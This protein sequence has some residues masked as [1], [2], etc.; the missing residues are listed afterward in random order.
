MRIRSR[1]RL[2]VRREAG[3]RL[4][5]VRPWCVHRRMLP[6]WQ[7]CVLKD[8]F[9]SS[10]ETRG[11]KVHEYILLPRLLQ[12]HADVQVEGCGCEPRKLGVLKSL[13]AVHPRSCSF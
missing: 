6:C 2:S 13:L 12:M 7:C 10:A 11:S 3:Q 4:D 5:V 8:A 1:V 9:D